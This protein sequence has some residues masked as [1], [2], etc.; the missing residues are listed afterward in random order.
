VRIEVL[1]DLAPDE[2]L[3]H[4]CSEEIE[5]IPASFVVRADVRPKYGPCS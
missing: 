4:C 2:K 1:H 5:I 3:C